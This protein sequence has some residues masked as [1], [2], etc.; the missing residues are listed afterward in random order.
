MRLVSLTSDFGSNSIHLASAR[1]DLYHKIS[2]AQLIDIAHNIAPCDVAEAAY[3]L[4][5][6]IQ[7]YPP[8]T[9]HIIAVDHED[10][11][12]HP[13]I[14]LVRY[15]D[16]FLVSYNTGLLSMIVA[17]EKLTSYQLG[18]YDGDHFA[19][20]QNALSQAAV[21]CLES[22]FQIERLSGPAEPVLKSM[23]MA[24]QSENHLTGHVM[25]LDDRGIAYT[26]I[27]RNTYQKF[28]EKGNIEI[29]L[30]RF[31]SISEIHRHLAEAK[32]G[33]PA[34]FFNTADLLCIGIYLEDTRPM[35][36]FKKGHTIIIEKR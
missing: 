4:R 31:E 24:I 15:R 33:L 34:A 18:V 16:Q 19:S 23:M 10:R 29:R 22:G 20:I 12:K 36:G 17:P 27:D 6:F 5:A 32:P 13:E 30:T 28:A 26:N 9:V 1:A 7:D 21:M 11:Q 3:I 14:L 2:G 8:N 25:Y 35:L